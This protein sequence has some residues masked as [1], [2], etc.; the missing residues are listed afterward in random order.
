MIY[1]IKLLSYKHI[2]LFG[3]EKKSR[4]FEYEDITLPT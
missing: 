1:N 3:N 2:Y 4:Y